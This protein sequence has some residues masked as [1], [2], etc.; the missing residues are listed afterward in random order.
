[1]S[2]IEIYT[3][4][5]IAPKPKPINTDSGRVVIF[6]AA[7]LRIEVGRPYAPTHI[8]MMI[9]TIGEGFDQIESNNIFPPKIK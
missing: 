2:A 7:A 9:D 3:M 8:I 1:M 4:A 5:L 6:C